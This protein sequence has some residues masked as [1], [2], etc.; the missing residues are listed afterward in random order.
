MNATSGSHNVK[1][2]FSLLQYIT[3]NS[4]IHAQAYLICVLSTNWWFAWWIFQYVYCNCCC[5]AT[6]GL[7][8]WNA[9]TAPIWPRHNFTL[10]DIY[11]CE[12]G[13]RHT[14]SESLARWKLTE[15]IFHSVC[16]YKQYLKQTLWNEI[17]HLEK[18]FM[19]THLSIII[20]FPSHVCW[21]VFGH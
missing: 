20:L 19:G 13:R 4:L 14:W 15:L 21:H 3:E 9:D 12:A 16:T 5:T 1:P 7:V 6:T 11:L 10:T 17:W 2:I 8:P 18:P